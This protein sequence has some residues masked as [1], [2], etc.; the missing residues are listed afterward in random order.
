MTV[1]ASKKHKKAENFILKC[2]SWFRIFPKINKFLYLRNN[3]H[4]LGCLLTPFWSP[5]NRFWS[6]LALIMALFVLQD[7]IFTQNHPYSA[8]KINLSFIISEKNMIFGENHFSLSSR[9]SYIT[10]TVCHTTH[11]TLLARSE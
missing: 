5:F 2:K 6:E 3:F 11:S 9:L 7:G 8:L 10:L 4:D 1:I